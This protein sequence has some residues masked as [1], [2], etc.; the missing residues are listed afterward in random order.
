MEIRQVRHFVAVA[1]SLSFSQA[2]E[3]VNLT[4]QAV[5]KSIGELEKK[6]SIKLLERSKHSVA[7]TDSAKV[8][9]PYMY[10]LLSNVERLNDAVNDISG[11]KEGNLRIGATPTFLHEIVLETLLEFQQMFPKTKITLERGDF[12]SLS[13]QL[14][15]GKLDMVLSTEP[16][17]HLQHLICL[18]KIGEDKNIIVVGKHHPLTKVDSCSLE[19]L[20]NYPMLKTKN[21]P[22]GEAWLEKLIEKRGLTTTSANITVGSST[23]GISWLKKT[24]HW[25]IIPSRRVIR[26]LEQGEIVQLNIDAENAH[27]NLV[28]ATRRHS[29]ESKWAHHYAQIVQNYLS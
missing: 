9:L 15:Q 13:L 11:V 27:C 12:H 29:D 26:P 8:L 24:N 16:E 23:F 28:M 19:E 21:F 10:D 7:L 2:A 14:Q 3:E 20:L 22:P 1:E 18:K 25:W 17:A 6:I 5:S 4:Q